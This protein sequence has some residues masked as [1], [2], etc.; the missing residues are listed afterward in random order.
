MGQTREQVTLG[1]VRKVMLEVISELS[2]STSLTGKSI[3]DETARRLQVGDRDKVGARRVLT[4]LHDLLRTGYLAWGRDLMNQGEPWVHVTD[5][6]NAALRQLS[7]DP[8]NPDGYFAYLDSKLS[9]DPVARSYL[10]EALLTYNSGC[11][12]A[13]AVM[14]GAAVERLVLRLGEEIAARLSALGRPVPSGLTDWRV[15]TVR[16]A[17]CQELDARKRAMPK[18]LSESYS[19]YWLAFAEQV[20]RVRN[21]AGHPESIDPVTPESVHAALLIFP[22]LAKLAADLETWVQSP[23][24]V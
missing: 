18:E 17:I 3:A 8:A 13:T 24:F 20:R 6:G 10:G 4:S 11:H 22:E 5:R 21:D 12:K 1:N 14:V 16:D 15:K 23:A 7:R 9:L 2:Q 19:A